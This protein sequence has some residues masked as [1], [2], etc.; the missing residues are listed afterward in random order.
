MP[1][2]IAAT[3]ALMANKVHNIDVED[4]NEAQSAAEGALLSVHKFEEY[5]NKEKRT[6]KPTIKLFCESNAIDD[7]NRGVVYAESQN[8]A[9][10]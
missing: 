1:I 6:P 8:F 10:V 3:K 2:F 5:R 7:W 9:R 4:F